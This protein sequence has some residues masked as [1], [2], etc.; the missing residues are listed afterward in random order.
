M[1][2]FY[3]KPL[4]EEQFVALYMPLRQYSRGKSRKGGMYRL[5]KAQK[6]YRHLKKE[7]KF[8]SGS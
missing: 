6:W 4:T 2:D 7:F 8:F 1:E 3:D 5:S